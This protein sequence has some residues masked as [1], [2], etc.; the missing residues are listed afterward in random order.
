MAGL[1][2]L[3]VY[4]LSSVAIW[5]WTSGIKSLW[6]GNLL[7]LVLDEFSPNAVS[8]GLITESLVMSVLCI[9]V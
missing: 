9:V 8:K 4:T 5:L 3:T 6:S 2:L 7:A 1:A